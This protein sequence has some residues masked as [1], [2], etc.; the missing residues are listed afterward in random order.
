MADPP[1]YERAM[2]MVTR[3]VGHPAMIPAG[4]FVIAALYALAG[5]DVANISISIMTFLLL[6]VLQH[7]QTK[8]SQAAEA[9]LDELLR[10]IP[11]ARNALIG[12][13]R[14]PA[15]EIEREREP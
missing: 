14:R 12:L 13:D 4:L 3:G 7:S 10:A 15:E 2:D 6:P 11:E 8:D 1:V 9:K 5:V